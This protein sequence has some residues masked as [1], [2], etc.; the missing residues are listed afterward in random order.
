MPGQRPGAD[1][2]R[3]SSRR[4]ESVANHVP[5]PTLEHE[6]ARATAEFPPSGTTVSQRDAVAARATTL[7]RDRSKA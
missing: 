2:E 6:T 3:I 5:L 4:G 7:I 1:R